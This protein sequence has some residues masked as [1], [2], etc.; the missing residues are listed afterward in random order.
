M[1][2]I[3]KVFDAKFSHGVWS[4]KVTQFEENPE[5]KFRYCKNSKC[6]KAAELA[7]TNLGIKQNLDQHP[8][9]AESKAT[10]TKVNFK[11]I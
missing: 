10:V 4:H 3:C 9:E 2:N 5:K 7:M 6:H 8:E 11:D 1:C